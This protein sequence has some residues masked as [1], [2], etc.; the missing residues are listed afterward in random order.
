[1]VEGV[2]AVWIRVDDGGENIFGFV[3]VYKVVSDDFQD[4]VQKLN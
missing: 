3:E 4:K 1:M 2:D